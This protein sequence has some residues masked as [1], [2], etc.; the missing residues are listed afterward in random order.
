[1][2]LL[3]CLVIVALAAGPTTVVLAAG[4]P[5]PATPNS[6]SATASAAPATTP[7]AADP[8]AGLADIPE[9]QE[10]RAAILGGELKLVVPDG[11]ASVPA[12]DAA[13][14][15]RRA[16]FDAVLAE[17]DA[18]VQVLADRLANAAGG[19][20]QFALQKEIE[21]EKLAAGRRLLELQLDFA[22]RD[23]DQARIEQIQAAITAWDAP[24]PTYAPVERPA[25]AING[26]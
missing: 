4:D 8:A 23:G 15:E 21:Q 5:Q 13:A 6:T 16:A 20:A 14:A 26:R 10:E 11:A 3:R 18:K 7:P 2:T 24:A 22:T 1:M 9:N 19:E 17:Q 25:P 12:V